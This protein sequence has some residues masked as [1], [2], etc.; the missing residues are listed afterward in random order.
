MVEKQK[1][2]GIDRL[3][4]LLRS[5]G[6]ERKRFR[7]LP[8]TPQGVQEYIAEAANPYEKMARYWECETAMSGV[9]PFR[10]TPEELARQRMKQWHAF[11]RK[12]TKTATEGLGEK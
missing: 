11:R 3:A 9:D 10:N 2:Q 1:F 4:L 5:D 7:E 6:L 12:L 8:T